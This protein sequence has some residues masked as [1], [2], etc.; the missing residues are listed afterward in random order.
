MAL[1][2]VGV[3]GEILYGSNA[4]TL[5]ALSPTSVV[6]GTSG[7]SVEV[8]GAAFAPGAIAY[9]NG[10]ARTTVVVS[11]YLATIQLT[12]ADLAAIG[13]G[14]ITAI[15]PGG[16]LSN[17]L[18][19]S[20]TAP[21]AILASLSPVSALAGGAQFTLTLT[22]SGFVTGCVA[23]WDSTA[24][25]TT[26]VSATQ[27]TAIVP[28][29]LLA[30]ASAH[31]IT[32]V[33]PSAPASNGQTFTVIGVASLLITYAGVDITALVQVTSLRI[34]QVLTRRGD[35]AS[36]TIVDT[37]RALTF[38]GLATVVIA[39]RHGHTLFR[40]P[41]TNVKRTTPTPVLA[42]WKIT[43]QDASYYLGKV[44]VNKKYSAMT[45]AAIAKD[46]LAS[47]PPDVTIT[48]NN[49][50]ANLPILSYIAFSHMRL[51]DAFDKLV[52]NSAA[53]ALLLWDIDPN[54]DLHFV[55]SNHVPQA[56]VALTDLLPTQTGYANYLRDTF[57]YEEDL[58]QLA[59]QITFR[60]ATYLSSPAHVQTWVGNGQQ[61]S[62]PLDY[63]PDTSK[64]AGG[65]LPTVTV[66]G[67]ALVVAVDTGSGFGNATVLMSVGVN[68]AAIL[69]FLTAPPNGAAIV[70]SYVYDLPVLVRR[71]DQTS[72]TAR[73]TWEEYI[74]D[75][76]V[77][78]NSA[79]V[80]R[81]G[82]MLSQFARPL[83]RVT[84]DVDINYTGALAAGQ[85]ALVTNSEINLSQQMIVTD[86][87]I[88]GRAGGGYAYRLGLA[89][90][91]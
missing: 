90:Y 53:I 20:V 91:G 89:S 86:C 62:F 79:A 84:L 59:N 55:D 81:A 22:G 38:A 7:L 8:S 45:V 6:A 44:L 71:K 70:A 17:G 40:G 28:A 15:N 39:D 41:A 13:S 56:D 9:W 83:I 21:A 27:L 16:T 19:F 12:A 75:T 18:T 10:S 54:N 37:T 87:T 68:N 5:T 4:L 1:Y 64:A 52:K 61:A 50:Q 78:T 85:Q 14:T 63:L 46:L 82:S 48:T 23:N 26:V 33:N 74:V 57:T 65:Y 76:T 73:G 30:T 24:L 58:S 36:F 77:A 2:G 69:Q 11:N 34:T 29:S 25:T 49:V 47:F 42:T 80:Q 60:G 67:V 43:A 51:S 35:T 72:I 32:A 88:S 66:A 3:Y 31:D